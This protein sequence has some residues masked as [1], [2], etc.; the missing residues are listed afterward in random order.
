MK[1]AVIPTQSGNYNAVAL[2]P[3]GGNWE[4]STPVELSNDLLI[5]LK[6]QILQKLALYCYKFSGWKGQLPVL[7]PWALWGLTALALCSLWTLGL[8]YII[9]YMWIRLFFFFDGVWSLSR[10]LF[11]LKGIIKAK[12]IRG[13]AASSQLVVSIDD[14]MPRSD[15]INQLSER[16]YIKNIMET[17]PQT[18][19]YYEEMLRTEEPWVFS[20]FPLGLT[21][22]LRR[23]FIGPKIP[24]PTLI[25][26]L[27]KLE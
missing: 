3:Y 11:H 19:P 14:K 23:M 15:G 7:L 17:Y 22:L 18:K 26:D 5:Q 10:L 13:N 12:K 21:G 9:L 20:I 1:I 25:F 8:K 24:L 6:A 16:E 2:P 27:G 4:L